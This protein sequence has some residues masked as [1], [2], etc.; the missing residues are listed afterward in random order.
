VLSILALF[1][2]H[3]EECFDSLLIRV[4]WMDR[5][6]LFK[7]KLLFDA[8]LRWECC[9]GAEFLTCLLKYV[10]FTKTGK[11]KVAEYIEFINN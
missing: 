10:V 8:A 7:I 3:L 2:K 6:L 1:A 11:L 9:F 4:L 5:M